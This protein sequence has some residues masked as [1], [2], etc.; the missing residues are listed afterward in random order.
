MLFS[1]FQISLTLLV[2][3]INCLLGMPVLQLSP[4]GS[5]D[6]LG[7]VSFAAFSAFLPVC[8]HCQGLC[9]I[10][11]Y[12]HLSLYD[13]SHEHLLV[14]CQMALNFLASFILFSALLLAPS[15]STLCVQVNACSLVASSMFSNVPTYLSISSVI[16]SSLKPPINCSFNSLPYSL[17]S[18]SVTFIHSLPIHSWADSLLFLCNL[19]YCNEIII[20][21]WHGLNVL[22]K[23]DNNPFMV[24]HFC[25][26]CMNVSISNW[27]SQPSQF[28]ILGLIL[29]HILLKL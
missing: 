9:P 25:F 14:F 29:H 10:V 24:L 2:H 3:L 17:Y 8:R 4:Q 1:F 27:P 22:L 26:S 18:H 19:Q 13:V 7:M 5:A 12:L 23:T 11:Q 21:L 16:P 6:C 15:A 20:Q 28:L